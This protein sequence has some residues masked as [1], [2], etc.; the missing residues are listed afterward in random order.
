MSVESPKKTDK[1]FIRKLI[2]RL[3]VFNVVD[4]TLLLFYLVQFT[5]KL[6]P[7]DPTSV[8]KFQPIRYSVEAF[9]CSAVVH[10]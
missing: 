6:L 5:R 7:L 3:V 4:K 9:L 2:S 10:S 8:F 1:P